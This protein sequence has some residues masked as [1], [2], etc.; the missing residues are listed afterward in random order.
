MLEIGVTLSGADDAAA[1]MREA[2]DESFRVFPLEVRPESGVAGFFAAVRRGLPL[3]PPLHSDRGWDALADSLWEGLHSIDSG[4]VLIHWR[5]ATGFR[6]TCPEVFDMCLEVLGNTAASL[7]DR[8]ATGGR[9]TH[10][11]VLI[12]VSS[13]SAK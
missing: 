12:E 3:D 13:L 9:T 2:V 6:D 7:A 8:R 1:S 10:V 4:R 11:T 5:K